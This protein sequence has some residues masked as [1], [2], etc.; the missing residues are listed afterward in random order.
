M[1]NVSG[2]LEAPAGTHGPLKVKD[3]KIFA[4]EKRFRIFGVNLCFAA[5]FPT[6]DE[7]RQIAA[8]MGKFGINCVRFHHMDMLPAPDGI[9]EAD[10][11]TLSP[12]QLDR[13]DFLIAEL[14]KNGIYADL[15]LHV[16]RTY[17]DLPTWQGMPG[18]F[19][20]VDNFYPQMIEMQRAYA[21][22]LLTHTNRYTQTRY[23][24]EPAIALIEVNNENALL[25]EWWSG[26]LDGMPEL[27]AGELAS[28]WNGWLSKKYRDFAELKRAWGAS[29]S[30]LGREQLTNGDFAR[31]AER[32]TLEQHEGAEATLRPE[33]SAG[34]AS[35]RVKIAK[36]GRENWHVQMGQAGL[37][38]KKDQPYTLRFRAKADAPRHLSVVAS[39]AHEPWQPLWSAG[40]ELTTDWQTFQFTFLPGDGDD[41]GRIVFSNL[42]GQTGS[43]WLS[44]VSLR[45]GGVMGL[46]P[47]EIA[48]HVQIFRKRDFGSRTAEAQ[49]DWI[50]FLWETETEY[51]GGMARFLKHDL[52]TKALL[53]GTQ[54]GWSPYP[55][56]AEFDVIDSHSYWQHPH[57]PGRQWDMEN[58][59]VNNVPM[60]GDGSGG[61]LPHLGLSRVA[62]KPF[63]CTE[64]NHAAPNTYVAETFPLIAA[65]AAMQDWDGVF[66]FA[67]CHRRDDWNARRISGFFDI[68]QHPTKMATLPASVAMFVRGDFHAPEPMSMAAPSLAE[69]I[70]QVRRSGP[71][72]GAD[73]FGVER[74]LALQRPVGVVVPGTTPRRA[75]AGDRWATE[76]VWHPAEQKGLVTVDTP[77]SKGIVGAMAAGAT[78]ALRGVSITAGPTRQSWATLLITAIDADDLKSP[79]RVL[80][81]A[82]G[83]AE[84]TAMGWKN[85][86][87]T[88]VGSDWGRAPSLV[89]GITAEITLPAPAARLRA[90]AL[91]ERGQRAA[92]LNVSDRAGKSVLAIGPE[93][94]TLW[95]EVECRD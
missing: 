78:V 80:V 19:K 32:W 14:K 49:R 4:G 47:G 61:T 12:G 86:D 39:Q 18:F 17:P 36:T 30:P 37:T 71:S 51:W 5:N 13:L 35:L 50:R 15:N 46:R 7:S 91:D 10:R 64:Y 24:D 34:R 22:D 72:L 95:Y 20:G 68:D 85:A 59:T 76:F 25:H 92:E 54:M 40:A 9:W 67:Y 48:G 57:F 3:G 94:K 2:W 53:V 6:H 87:K 33:R 70:D 55:I 23:V 27:Y 38:L 82:C 84:N 62:G 77:R 90:W 44:E 89:E 88:T 1:T 43:V 66:A 81:T 74:R 8:R 31:G 93:H 83:Y 28:Q 69:L 29:E 79:G 75:A 73:R 52:K 56:Q 45:P 58:W 60:T 21:R 42:A 63:I 16:S 11:R 65:Y 41:R 26:E